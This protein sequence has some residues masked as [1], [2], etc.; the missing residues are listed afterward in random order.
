[1][2]ILNSCYTMTNVSYSRRHRWTPVPD[3]VRAHVHI[4]TRFGVMT[5]SIDCEGCERYHVED[6]FFTMDE[7]DYVRKRLLSLRSYNSLEVNLTLQ[8]RVVG[9]FQHQVTA[10][11]GF[12]DAYILEVLARSEETNVTVNHLFRKLHDTIA[13]RRAFRNLYFRCFRR[14]F[15]PGCNQA[16]KLVD[17]HDRAWKKKCIR[18]E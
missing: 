1:M 7:D 16:R 11:D 5:L 6:F 15:A 10:T 18:N 8:N 9:R 12:H 13:Q 4:G 14:A 17:E 3:Y 2:T